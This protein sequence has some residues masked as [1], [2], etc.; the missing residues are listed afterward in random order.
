MYVLT[1]VFVFLFTLGSAWVIHRF[2]FPLSGDW[3]R[4]RL[5]TCQVYLLKSVV[6]FSSCISWYLW[7]ELLLYFISSVVSYVTLIYLYSSFMNYYLFYFRCIII[8]LCLWSVIFIYCIFWDLPNFYLQRGILSN[9]IPA[10][11]STYT[12]IMDA[13]GWKYRV[14]TGFKSKFHRMKKLC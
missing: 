12:L 11:V 3:N 9:S 14:V 8:T 7:S 6:P 2:G 5:S 1:R 10:W 13:N 4:W